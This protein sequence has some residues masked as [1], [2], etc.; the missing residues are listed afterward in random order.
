MEIFLIM[1][2]FAFMMVYL[3]EFNQLIKIEISCGGF[4]Q[5]KQMK[6]NLRVKQQRYTVK[7]SKIR[8][9]VP[10]NIQPSIL[11]REKVKKRLTI[12]SNH[13]LVQVN[14]CRPTPKTVQWGI[15]YY[16]YIFWHINRKSIKWSYIRDGINSYLKRWEESKT[17]SHPRLSAMTPPENIYLKVCF[18]ILK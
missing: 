2:I 1:S 6:M 18:I 13:L 15:K 8:R 5:M 3:I 11:F 16:F 4:Y 10:L 9:G 17:Q 7:G 14:N 12:G